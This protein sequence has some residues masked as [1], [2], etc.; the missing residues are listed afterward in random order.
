MHAHLTPSLQIIYIHVYIIYVP[1]GKARELHGESN[2]GQ[3]SPRTP[4]Q[5]TFQPSARHVTRYEIFLK[6][7]SQ[8]V[9]RS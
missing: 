6:E 8:K 5:R 7:N 9:T 3:A 2:T 4:T 1:I